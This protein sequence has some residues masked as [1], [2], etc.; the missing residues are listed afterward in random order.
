MKK[1]GKRAEKPHT[2][3]EIDGEAHTI[4]EW[5]RIY[6]IPRGVVTKRLKKGYYLY[7]A[8]QE[9]PQK[10]NRDKVLGIQV[11]VNGQVYNSI[12]KLAEAYDLD[13]GTLYA[14]YKRGLRGADLVRPPNGRR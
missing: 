7:E 10:P 13:S 11:E 8:L 3:Y 12:K 9:P 2:L 1:I 6:N 4:A 5:C 14:R